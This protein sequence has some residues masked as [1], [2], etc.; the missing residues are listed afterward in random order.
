MESESSEVQDSDEEFL[1]VMQ[2]KS[3]DIPVPE[4]EHVC[5]VT[6]MK[7]HRPQY[8]H[9][10]N[11]SYVEV[12]Q[13]SEHSF[14]AT[15][16]ECT[17]GHHR[18]SCHGIDVFTYSSEC[19]TLYE[20]RTAFVRLPE[21][22][23]NFVPAMIKVGQTSSIKKSLDIPVPEAEHVCPVTI[24]KRHRPQ[25]GH[26]GNGSYVEVQQDSEHSFEATFVECTNGHHRPSCH[27][28]DVFTYSS[29]CVTLYEWRTAFVRLPESNVN[30][31][32]A[33]IKVG[34]TS[35]IVFQSLASAD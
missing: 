33:M 16:V 27:G 4:A 24:M 34:Q 17:N 11:G 32:P 8:G 25:Y 31:V 19:V 1:P 5:P 9:M 30:F 18:P 23:V 20:W 14:E 21:S 13:D 6:I 28:I 26:M 7:R 3:L 12:Q 29:E 35:S 2:K 15:F 10:G 22:N